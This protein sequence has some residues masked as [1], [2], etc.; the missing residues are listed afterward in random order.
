M[1]ATPMCP[2]RQG[3][4]CLRKVASCDGHRPS[5]ALGRVKIKAR[6]PGSERSPVTARRV[7]TSP[8]TDYRAFR[9]GLTPLL[10]EKVSDRIVA[11][12]V[13]GPFDLAQAVSSAPR[14]QSST[15]LPG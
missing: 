7:H 1:F 5:W 6:S 11:H 14:A 15:D 9:S 8:K 10:R 13:L 2:S 12:S 4:D 3:I